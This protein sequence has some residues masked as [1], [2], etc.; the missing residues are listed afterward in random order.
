MNFATL[1][2]D[3]VAVSTDADQGAL[4]FLESSEYE[5]VGGGDAANGY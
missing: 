1:N 3:S 4:I 2:V 5:F